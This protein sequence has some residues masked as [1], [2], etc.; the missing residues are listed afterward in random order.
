MQDVFS[1]EREH[2]TSE[3]FVQSRSRS[4]PAMISV[5]Q[6]KRK[7]ELIGYILIG[8]DLSNVYGLREE[9]KIAE[10]ELKALL[11]QMNPHFLFNSLNTVQFYISRNEEEKANEYLSRF[12]VL[13]RSILEA[14]EKNSI[15]LKDEIDTINLYLEMESARFAGKFSYTIDVQPDISQSEVKIPPMIIQ[16]FIENAIWHG[17]LPKHSDR[18]LAIAFELTGQHL[19]CV[20]EDN[21]IGRKRS[22]EINKLLKPQHRSTAIRNIQERVQLINKQIKDIGIRINIEDRL[23]PYGSSEG[24]RVEISFPLS[25]Q[26]N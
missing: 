5:A 11:R 21:G 15:C 6:V 16:P 24:T 8:N 14:S 12:S 20:V 26:M 19:L 3:I 25:F 22:G 1:G 13:M 23:T 4:F 9:K 18:Q 17:L 7:Q 2:H 10:L